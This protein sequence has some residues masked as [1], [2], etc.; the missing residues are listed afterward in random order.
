MRSEVLRQQERDSIRLW[1]RNFR[2]VITG[3]GGGRIRGGDRSGGGEVLG[4]VVG[5]GAG[6]EMLGKEEG[7]LVGGVG[8]S[9]RE[10]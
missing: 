5:Q 2:K 8:V 7:H 4:A 3:R 6:G 9:K 10:E 1:F